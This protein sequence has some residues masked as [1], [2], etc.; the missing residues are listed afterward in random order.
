MKKKKYTDHNTQSVSQ[1]NAQP[2]E[3]STKEMVKKEGMYKKYA[4]VV[5]LP[6]F[7]VVYVAVVSA[8]SNLEIEGQPP[9]H[10]HHQEMHET[11]E[12]GDY[13]RFR[14]ISSDTPLGEI[15]DTEEEFAQLQEMHELFQ[16]GNV[17]EATEIREELG[18][19]EHHKGPHGNNN[20]N[21][22]GKHWNSEKHEAVKQA[23][24]DNDYEAWKEAMGGMPGANEITEETFSL[25]V[26]A[27]MLKENGQYEEAQEI[28]EEIGGFMGKGKCP[29]LHEHSEHSERSERSEHPKGTCADLQPI[30]AS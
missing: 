3:A 26:E 7:M 2:M 5:I 11:I 19:P 16:E 27:H 1:E 25:I 22:N 20:G 17:E 4:V 14:E 24:E 18:L 6:I 12:K 13:D 29:H 9:M 15:V 28:W 30:P 10:R 23:I 8:D 21:G